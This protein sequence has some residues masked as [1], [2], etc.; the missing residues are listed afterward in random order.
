[1]QFPLCEIGPV[2]MV[3]AYLGGYVGVAGPDHRFNAGT[4]DGRDR[5]PPRPG[6]DHRDL[7]HEVVHKTLIVSHIL[8]P[9]TL[10]TLVL[11]KSDERNRARAVIRR[12][13]A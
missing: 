11:P 8:E 2:C 1:M 9:C 5:G 6:S 13:N 3:S 12:L 4:K 7:G 10:A